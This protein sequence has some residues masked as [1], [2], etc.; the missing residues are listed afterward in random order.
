MNSD[1][2]E[3]LL[4][5]RLWREVISRNRLSA[6]VHLHLAAVTV[7]F[8]WEMYSTQ[9][10]AFTST[11]FVLLGC[12]YRHLTFKQIAKTFLPSRNIEI[13]HY[14]SMLVLGAG[15]SLHWYDVQN[16]F[17]LFTLQGMFA[18]MIL[19]GLVSAGVP[20]NSGRPIAYLCLALPLCTLPICIFLMKDGMEYMGLTYCIFF[21]TCFNL[22][23]LK[24][25]YGYLKA[26]I[27]K[28]L[29]V[30]LERDRLQTLINAVPGYVCFIDN[31]M[32]YR[33]VNEFGKAIFNLRD[34]Q[35]RYIGEGYETSDF[36]HF[37]S[38]FM[39]GKRKTAISEIRFQMD[40]QDSTF[41][42][43]IQRI[44]DDGAVI[45]AIPMDEL[46]EI[47]EKVKAQEAKSFYTSKLISLGEMAAGI[48]HEINNP[49]A[50]ILASSDQIQR[51]LNKPVSSEERIAML[52][53]KIQRTV[54]RI[55]L[56]IKSL[57]SLARNGERDPYVPF[58]LEAIIEPS[59][60]ISRQRFLEE[61]IT[62]DLH[63]PIKDI[64]C[65]GQE[66]QLAQVMMNLLSNAVDAALDGPSP[67]WVRLEVKS[68]DEHVDICIQDSGPGIPNEIRHKI[69]DP[70]FTT[71]AINKGTG[72]GLSI[73]K[74]IMEQ[75]GGSLT[76]DETATHTTFIMRIRRVL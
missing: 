40:P 52:T 70:F 15:W 11:G 28:D 65:L 61:N 3:N 25:N 17:G 69:M 30:T 51:E 56:I 8:A 31:K 22:Y 75:H 39:A 5:A 35:D 36:T 4:T 13:L 48:A 55:S 67:R 63:C 26:F 29:S 37:V 73:S 42:V 10:M 58:K 9:P 34:Y 19:C 57:R 74:S 53:E 1:S 38:E 16:Y 62:L 47:R 7:A 50:I 12:I 33:A 64:V 46:I 54:E 20:A 71:K 60:E 41:I 43:S 23:Q 68:N 32:N 49:L 72:L 6:W 45:V 18:F 2:H 27:E 76:L 59:L 24:M 44:E 14:V 66:I 21:Y